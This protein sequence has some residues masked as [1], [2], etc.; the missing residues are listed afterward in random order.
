M[1]LEVKELMMMMM[2][3]SCVHYSPNP[4]TILR[5]RLCSTPVL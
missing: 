5:I 2:M 1:T 4:D 3:R